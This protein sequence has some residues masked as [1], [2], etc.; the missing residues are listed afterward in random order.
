MRR[1]RWTGS[2][3]SRLISLSFE[4]ALLQP[5]LAAGIAIIG[6]PA[7][8]LIHVAVQLWGGNHP[9]VV[10][11]EGE[12]IKTPEMQLAFWSAVAAVIYAVPNLLSETWEY[13]LLAIDGPIG[14]VYVFGAMKVTGC[15]FVQ[16]LGCKTSPA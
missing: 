6:G 7:V 4:R 14:L 10:T 8:Y 12:G 11:G 1:K 2:R 3:A 16:L 13:A 5:K 9:T 15:S